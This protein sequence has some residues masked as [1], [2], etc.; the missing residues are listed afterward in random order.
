M[1]KFEKWL[2]KHFEGNISDLKNNTPESAG[3]IAELMSAY[4]SAYQDGQEDAL[5]KR[6]VNNEIDD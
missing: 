1:N 2:T 6:E 3:V 4:E 5:T